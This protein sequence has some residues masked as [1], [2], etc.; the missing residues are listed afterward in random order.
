MTRTLWRAASLATAL[1]AVLLAPAMADETPKRGGILTYMI[2]AD[3]PPSFDA[4]REETYATIHSTAPF[5]STLIR[6][7]PMDPGS[8]DMV[9]DLCVEMPKPTENNTVYTFKIRPGVKFHDGT[10]LTA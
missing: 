5:Y 2:P 4:Q 9:C 3:A 8:P 1:T 6:A 7:N 10:P